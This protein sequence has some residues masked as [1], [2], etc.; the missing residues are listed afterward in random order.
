MCSLKFVELIR[1]GKEEHSVCCCCCGEGSLSEG[2]MKLEAE[3]LAFMEKSQN[4]DA[5]PTRKD[6]EKAGRV[7]LIEAIRNRGG[8]YSFGWDSEEEPPTDQE[9]VPE[10]EE[11]DFDIE[12]LRRRVEKYQ[13]SDSGSDFSSGDS[14]QPASS[15]GRSL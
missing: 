8:W 6:L 5:F 14:S 12:E 9:N 7:D 4:P 10:A 1:K 2:D 11:M 3:I 15:S 13:E